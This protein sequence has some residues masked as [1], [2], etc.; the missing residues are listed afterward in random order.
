MTK[1]KIKEK[2]KKNA[3]IVFSVL[4]LI[5][6]LVV[7]LLEIFKPLILN[8][9]YK[10]YSAPIPVTT[11]TWGEVVETEVDGDIYV[12]NNGSDTNTGDKESPFKTIERAMQKVSS[13]DKTEKEKIVVCIE[14]GAYNISSIKILEQHGGTERCNATYCGY[15]GEVV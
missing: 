5:V 6:A 13:L 15:G 8:L 2:S 10:N 11:S 14:S 12:S 4:L 7:M 9:V 3:I 1:T